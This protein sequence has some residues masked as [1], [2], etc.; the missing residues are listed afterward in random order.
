MN[1]PKRVAES[2]SAEG[3][4]RALHACS[5]LFSLQSMRGTVYCCVD[6]WQIV[7]ARADGQ[8]TRNTCPKI[9]LGAVAVHALHFAAE[10][11]R[12]YLYK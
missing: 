12:K 6:M 9:S 7:A 11:M 10:R 1:E 5:A 4:Q 8:K 2:V 3:A